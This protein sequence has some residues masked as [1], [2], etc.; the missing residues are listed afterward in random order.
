MACLGECDAAGMVALA[1]ADG[2]IAGACGFAPSALAMPEPV[3][4]RV[5]GREVEERLPGGATRLVTEVAVECV[6]ELANDAI[7]CAWMCSRVLGQT[8]W[9]RYADLLGG[10]EV[11]ECE[12]S[13]P[14]AVE[15][16][17][18]GR[19][20]SEFTCWFTTVWDVVA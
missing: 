7:G 12:C 13:A 9:G 18:S 20:V 2:G 4:C 3:V 11:L 14:G 8:E 10:C 19:F 6:R 5:A 1:L 15:R 16:D 17:G